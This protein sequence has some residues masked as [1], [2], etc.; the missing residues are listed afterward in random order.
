M[1]R[2]LLKTNPGSAEIRLTLS[3]RCSS[4][5]SSEKMFSG[6][7]VMALRSR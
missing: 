7:A 2:S 3:V 5:S 1:R 4:A 6:S